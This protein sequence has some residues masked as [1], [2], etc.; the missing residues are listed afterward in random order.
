MARMPDAGL[1][2]KDFLGFARARSAA[3]V[4]LIVAGALL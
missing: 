4:A 3:A 1:L 2:L